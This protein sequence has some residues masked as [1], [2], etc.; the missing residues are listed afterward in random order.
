MSLT[1]LLICV[2]F[3]D[4]TTRAG[5]ETCESLEVLFGDEPMNG[6]WMVDILKSGREPWVYDHRFGCP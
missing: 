6:I 2:K 5:K 4:E 3:W 1:E